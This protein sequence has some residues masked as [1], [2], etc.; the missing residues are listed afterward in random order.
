MTGLRV[1]RV[2]FG[3]IGF[4]LGSVNFA[5]A[6]LSRRLLGRFDYGEM[7]RRR[8]RNFE[9]LRDRL[10]SAPP[11][12][13]R[14]RGR[15]VPLDLSAAR[16]GQTRRGRGRCRP[17]ASRRWSSG[18]A[19]TPTRAGMITPMPGTCASTWWSCLST[20]TSRRSRSTTWPD[21]CWASAALLGRPLACP[22]S[23]APSHD[24]Q[25][26]PS[27][28]RRSR[29]PGPSAISVKSGQPARP[30]SRRLPLPHVGVALYVV[31]ASRGRPP[32]LHRG[33]T[34][35]RRADRHR[36][37]CD[38]RGTGAPASHRCRRSRSSARGAWGPTTS[39]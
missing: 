15:H 12:F 14:A 35:R 34:V 18:T 16:P 24:R 4:D 31:D 19:G 32:A 30:E 10:P 28:S 2:P 5:V 3:D 38:Q 25:R 22:H 36:A 6:P 26:P 17:R 11:C 7:R 9:L 33:G 1:P 37:A 21:G 23:S 39:T 20:R 29:T 13:R 8:R 27:P